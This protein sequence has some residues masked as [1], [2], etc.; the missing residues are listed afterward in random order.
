MKTKF[1]LFFA[2]RRVKRNNQKVFKL[3]QQE[4]DFRRIE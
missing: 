4:K 3:N 2:N 1:Y